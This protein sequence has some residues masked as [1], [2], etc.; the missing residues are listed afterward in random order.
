MIDNLN[1]FLLRHPRIV[2]TTLVTLLLACSYPAGTITFQGHDP[3][4]PWW[5]GLLLSGVSCVALLSRRA[6][7]R[8]AA[9][10]A[11]GCA[12]AAVAL[13]YLVTPLL[14][15]PLMVAFYALAVRTGRRTANAFAFTGVVLLTYTALIVGPVGFP[16]VLE[17]LSPAFWLL[18]PTSLGT[19]NRLHRACVQ[20][21]RARAEHAERTREEEARN[22]V[23]EERLRVARDLHD[24]VAH[25]LVLAKIQADAVARF[26]HTRPDE[27]ERLVAELTGTTAAALRELKATVGLLRESD[28]PEA[29]VRE[30]AIPGVA[31]L[32]DLA[33]SF[34]G[35]G[36]AVLVTEEGP[37]RPLTAGADL[38]AYRIVQEALTNVTKHGSGRRAEVRLA[39]AHDLLTISVTNDRSRPRP[40]SP[41]RNGGF[42]IIGMRERAR[43]VEG[44]LHAGPRPQGGF[45]VV[46]ELPLLSEAIGMPMEK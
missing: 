25:H 36:L 40:N 23:T 22:R 43:S 38:A 7:P 42:G 28:G 37:S 1:R 33:A 11:L 6:R 39:Y 13:G 16:D 34:A 18:L 45:E 35:A 8:T 32:P 27:A 2:D 3:T 26:L 10:V 19:T 46:A 14:L 41:G 44:S 4:V 9:A 15:G 17:L 12:I 5:L 29:E 30:A 21:V 20:A 31:R 24:V